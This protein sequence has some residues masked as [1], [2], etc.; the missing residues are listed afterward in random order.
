MQRP[1][2]MRVFGI[3]LFGLAVLLTAAIAQAGYM[4]DIINSNPIGYWRLDDASGSASAANKISGGVAG[5]YNNFEAADYGK[6]GAI[7]GDSD[8]AAGFDGSNNYISIAES[9]VSTIGT[10][11]FSVEMW[12][13]ASNSTRGDLFN[14]KNGAGEVDFGLF[15]ESSKLNLWSTAVGSLATGST[16]LK[17]NQWYHMV[18]TRDGSSN[19]TAYINGVEQFSVGGSTENFGSVGHAIFIGVN[20]NGADLTFPVSGSIDEVAI[21]SSAMSQPTALAH[22]NAGITVPEPGTAILLGSA[23]IGLLCYAWRKRK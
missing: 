8:T 7:A 14:Y 11:A 5:T 16:E 1:N 13:N 12:F 4:T 3:G 23:L 17:T 22:Y 9:A 10:G 15:Y 2:V 18:L 21:Y 20:Y 6:P 19:L